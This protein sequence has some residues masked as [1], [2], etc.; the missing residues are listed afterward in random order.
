VPFLAGE[1]R[2]EYADEPQITNQCAQ[3]MLVMLIESIER[4]GRDW[5]SLSG[6]HVH[7][8]AL[9]LNTIIRFQVMLVMEPL[10]GALF[11]NG[12]VQRKTHAVGPQ[13]NSTALPS[14]T[15]YVPRSIDNPIKRS[16]NH[17]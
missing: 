8:F 10:L 4:S 7:H 15:R 9:S 6:F 1:R 14:L 12:I 17:G 3:D 13:K 16:D 2:I 11:D 5:V